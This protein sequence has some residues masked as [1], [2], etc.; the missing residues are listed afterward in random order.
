MLPLHTTP[1]CDE[2]ARAICMPLKHGANWLPRKILIIIIIIKCPTRGLATLGVEYATLVRI[3]AIWYLRNR[4]RYCERSRAQLRRIVFR[5]RWC[6]DAIC[7]VEM[8]RAAW[9]CMQD[10][11][12]AWAKWQL[13]WWVCVSRMCDADYMLRA[14]THCG[15]H[16]HF[17]RAS[18]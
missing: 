12:T 18:D 16:W 9:R 11:V 7:A 6:Y 13:R 17:L 8:P 2:G 5:C 10:K 15:A 4:G 14:A 1:G 3:Y